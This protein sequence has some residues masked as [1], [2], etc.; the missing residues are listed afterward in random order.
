MNSN[1]C[2]GPKN[3]HLNMLMCATHLKD[4][5][6]LEIGHIKHETSKKYY[7]V[8]GFIKPAEGHI[9]PTNTVIIPTRKYFDMI[10][11]PN[12]FVNEEKIPEN[13]VFE[14]NPAITEFIRQSSLN[15]DQSKYKRFCI[16]MLRNWTEQ[17]P[18]TTGPNANQKFM[19]KNMISLVSSIMHYCKTAIDT[20]SVKTDFKEFHL[21]IAKKDNTLAWV[22]L[23]EANMSDLMKY[24]LVNCYMGVQTAPYENN[25]RFIADNMFPNCVWVEDVG[26]VSLENISIPNSLIANGQ[27]P[28]TQN[29]TNTFVSSIR[30]TLCNDKV[31]EK[32]IV[33][34]YYMENVFRGGQ[35]ECL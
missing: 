1:P 32:N 27:A 13:R 18:V 8:G 4:F 2:T 24:F 35:D 20:Q 17:E 22:P 30:R 14:M 28:T 3:K 11:I 26:L 19:F 31:T 9:F 12:D 34:Q 15:G 21:R 16:E 29:Y 10:F 33:P 23:H 7:F 5:F 25:N 6:G